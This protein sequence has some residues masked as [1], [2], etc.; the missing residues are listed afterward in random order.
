MQR[1]RHL[2]ILRR[3]TARPEDSGNVSGQMSPHFSLFFGK[4]DVG[5]Y[6]VPKKKKGHPDCYQWKVQKPASV[7]VWGMHRCPRH[8][9]S[10]YMWK[11]H[12]WGGLSLNF[13]ETMLPSRLRLIPGT[14]CLFQLDN[15]RPHS[16]RQQR[17]F[18]GIKCAWSVSY[19]KCMADEENQTTRPWT[20]VQL[21]TP[22]I[23][24]NSTWK[25]AIIDI[26]SLQTISRC[27]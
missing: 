21:N 5:F 12:W 20:V 16:A 25:I 9:W 15:A 13:G 1:G 6:Y 17:G 3:N 18:I 11:Y 14:Q 10:A 7:M 22:R 23:G 8:G 24:K 4:T 27:N 19:W 2:L 26:I